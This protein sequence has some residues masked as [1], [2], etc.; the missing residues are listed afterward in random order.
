VISPVWQGIEPRVAAEDRDLVAVL[1]AV[2]ADQ[3]ELL[4]HAVVIGDDDAGVAPDVEV[5]ERMQREAGGDAVGAGALSRELRQDA[6]AGVLDHGEVVALRD[7]HQLAHVGDLAGQLDRH[8]RLGL[9][10]DR[11]LDLVDV[12]A[13]G[14][15]AV[16]QHR[17]GAGFRDRADGGDEGV[18]GGDDLVA[19]ADAER[20]E[21]Q[22]ERVGAG[23]DADGVAHADQLGE[24][25]LEFGDGLAKGEVTGRNQPADL[26]QNGGGV[27][28]LLE[29]IGISNVVHVTRQ[30]EWS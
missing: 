5:L 16:D 25:L 24:A 9:F 26:G 13:E 29:Q 23:S 12:H 28:E 4:V 11:G 20:L 18:G 14:I 19:V 7:R 30:V 17:R 3:A 15:V 2:V 27:G 22:L 10:G 8:D 21:R 6:L 1:H